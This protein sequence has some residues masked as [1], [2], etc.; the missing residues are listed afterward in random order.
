MTEKDEKKVR[1]RMYKG[2]GFFLVIMAICALTGIVS[3]ANTY[4]A[5]DQNANGEYQIVYTVNSDG[6]Q[7]FNAAGV[8]HGTMD[9]DPPPAA[10]PGP[11][12]QS[13]CQDVDMNGQYGYALVAAS[14]ASGNQADSETWLNNGQADVHQGAGII[15][16]HTEATAQNAYTGPSVGFPFTGAYSYQCVYSPEASSIIADTDAQT[17][18][19]TTAAV[20]A[21]ATGIHQT[22]DLFNPSSGPNDG[23]RCEPVFCVHQFA[24]ALSPV[25]LPTEA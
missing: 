23:N 7:L 15:S 24:V 5:A 22:D 21:Q 11:D 2:I 20:E 9:T 3:A 6:S 13:V 14:D 18:D 10:G 8:A 19:D 25:T 4:V 1:C 16:P 17:L 12:Q